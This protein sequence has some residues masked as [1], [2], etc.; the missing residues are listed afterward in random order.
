[1]K[2]CRRRKMFTLMKYVLGVI[3]TSFIVANC[4]SFI[5]PKQPLNQIVTAQT[6]N[7]SNISSI[8]QDVLP[9]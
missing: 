6:V 5:S 4:L 7:Y 8:F 1:M 9:T 3:F 2:E